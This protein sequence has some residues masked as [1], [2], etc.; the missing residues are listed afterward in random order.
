MSET[1]GAVILDFW[2]PSCGP[3][4]GMAKDFEVV[5]DAFDPD[6]IR[7]CK[8]NTATHGMLAAPF[9]IRSVP[10]ILFINKGKILDAHVGAMQAPVLGKRAEWLL[11]CSQKKPGF[12]SRLFS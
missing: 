6:E 2:S 9:N 12:F 10:T 5:S 3:C 1:G 11:K 8:V 4:L 7:F